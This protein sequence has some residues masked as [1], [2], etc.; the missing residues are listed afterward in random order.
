MIQKVKNWTEAERAIRLILSDFEVDV[1]NDDKKPNVA[2]EEAIVKI[3]RL[4][5]YR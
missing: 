3:A 2:R 1:R 4:L 5:G